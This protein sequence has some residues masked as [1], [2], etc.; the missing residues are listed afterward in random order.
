MKRLSDRGVPTLKYGEQRHDI[1]K[2]ESQGASIVHTVETANIF[3]KSTLGPGSF[4]GNGAK[5]LLPSP[6]M[7]IFFLFLSYPTYSL[8]ESQVPC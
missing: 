1:G 7:A 4:V 2:K 3:I 8:Q 6:H 5:V